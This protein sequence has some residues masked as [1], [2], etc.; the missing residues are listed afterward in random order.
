MLAAINSS[1]QA[2]V[3]TLLGAFVCRICHR[4]PQNTYFKAAL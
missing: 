4:I 3:I 1:A 2:E